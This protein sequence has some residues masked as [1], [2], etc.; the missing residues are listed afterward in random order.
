MD[1]SL[2][3]A[4]TNA[5]LSGVRV[6]D[7]GQFDAGA[8]CAEI[9][10]WYGADV[11]KIEPPSGVCARHATTEKPGVDSYEFILLNANK[12]SVT[13]DLESTAGK[14]SLSKLI[15][16]ADVVVENMAPGVV[17]RLGF[18]YD[19]VRE[20]N[21]RII[22]AQ[23]KCFASGGPRAYYLG[24]DMV[25]QSIGG[26]VSQTGFEG[27]APLMAGPTAG[28]TGVALHCAQGI[29]AALHQRVETGRGQRVEVAMQES[30]INLTRNAH[31]GQAMQGKP[32]ERSGNG[33]KTDSVPSNL[34]ACS[35]GGPNDYVFIHISRAA[36][37]HWN[38]LLKV[39]GREDLVGDARFASASARVANRDEVNRMVSTWCL[40]HTKG[41][42]MEA[43]NRAGAPAGAIFDMQDLL[44]NPHLRK[45]GT[46]VTVE[47]PLR[48]A[49]TIPGWPVKMSESH[50]PVRSA[51][52]LGAHTQEVLSEWLIPRKQ[53]LG[54]SGKD[55]PVMTKQL[56]QNPGDGQ[57]LSGVRVLDLSHNEA[58]PACTEA[59]AW[60][61]ADV[62][63]VEEPSRGDRG[64]Y[65]NSDRPGADAHYFIFL[66]ANKRSMTC[67]LKSERG[68]EV[69]R[70]L[71]RNVDIMIENMGPG[72]IERLGFDYDTVR[73]LNPKIIFAQI[74]GYATDGPYAKYVCFDAIAQATGGA[75][76]ITGIDGELPL[77]P[78]ST[79]GDS[80]TGMHCATGILAALCQRRVTGRGQKIEMAMQEGVINFCRIGF[81]RYLAAGKPPARLGSRN[82]YR[83]KGGGPNDYCSVNISE[84]DNERW[85]RL[86][87]AIGKPDLIDDPRFASPR[88]RAGHGDEVDA[89]LSAWCLE[90]TKTEAMDI[91]QAAGVPAG[92]VFDTQELQDDPYLR[93]SG[94]FATIEHPLRGPMVMPAFAVKMSDTYV[95]VRSAPLLGAHTESVL[96]EW[97]GLSKQEIDELGRPATDSN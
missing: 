45:R 19:V 77:K 86:L 76:S 93:K 29:L 71:I 42:V 38:A 40:E 26:L 56:P 75:L 63:K 33:S 4:G 90:R 2:R 17:E 67:D 10:A 96:S 85:Q 44:E 3:N 43:V 15:A 58:G 50:V 20:L 39:M 18:G 94:M 8:M 36:I 25:A 9:L 92:A 27:G 97:L 32:L 57:A 83:C 30:V 72:V 79:M 28:D 89:L 91:V 21:P 22:F 68:K 82:L 69:L 49:V 81:A 6:L 66:N 23:I 14:E 48:G 1:Q 52:L 87:R 51:P 11:V 37:K 54:V 62:V 41:D 60:L 65:G 47:H 7:L 64:R 95:P 55:L 61:G 84:I 35:P 12:R 31:M 24:T 59:L 46:F 16:S 78:G 34:Y 74:K 13:C 70:K 73:Q 80:G 5:A 88:E 53:G